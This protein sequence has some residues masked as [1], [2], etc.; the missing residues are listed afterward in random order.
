VVSSPGFPV[1]SQRLARNL[2]GTVRRP[3]RERRTRPA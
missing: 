1:H 3:S 2:G